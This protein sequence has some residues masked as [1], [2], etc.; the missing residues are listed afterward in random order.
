MLGI[1]NYNYMYL[2]HSITLSHIEDVSGQTFCN[3]LH[4][5]SQ[6]ITTNTR[7]TKLDIKFCNFILFTHACIKIL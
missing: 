5:S 3:D 4:I 2:T 7:P 1:Y 6:H